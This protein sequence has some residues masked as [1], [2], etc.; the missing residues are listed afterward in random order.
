METK[1]FIEKM[2]QFL[3][4]PKD[5]FNWEKEDLKKELKGVLQAYS[6]LNNYFS[7]HH[8][9]T[10]KE[11]P[12][13]RRAIEALKI[14]ST[15]GDSLMLVDIHSV[16]PTQVYIINLKDNKHVAEYG[17]TGTVDQQNKAIAEIEGKYSPTR[18]IIHRPPGMEG[19]LYRVLE[20]EDTK[21]AINRAYCKR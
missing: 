8:L 5:S 20:S 12:P 15:N 14:L 19:K 17:I 1:E 11:Y 2:N 3:E 4:N 18:T 10:Q 21:E 9:Y 7:E 6:D 16:R 13:I